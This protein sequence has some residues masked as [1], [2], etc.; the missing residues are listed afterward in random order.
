MGQVCC[1]AVTDLGGEELAIIKGSGK[2][3]FAPQGFAHLCP[4][5]RVGSS[6]EVAC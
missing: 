6:W 5:G 4:L 3:V 2:V 1:A